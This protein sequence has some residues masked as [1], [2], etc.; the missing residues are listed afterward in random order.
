[1][2]SLGT[3]LAASDDVQ[4]NMAG[5]LPEMIEKLNEMQ[6]KY[7]RVAAEQLKP[8]QRRVQKM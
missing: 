6:E 2:D 5:N 7:I 8:P 3:K 4:L 1:M